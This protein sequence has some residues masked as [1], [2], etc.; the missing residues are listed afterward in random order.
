M[1]YTVLAQFFDVNK[2]KTLARWKCLW[3]TGDVGVVNELDSTQ[4]EES[5]M[6]DQE[7]DLPGMLA[8]AE[9]VKAGEWPYTMDARV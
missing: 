9:G 8:L 7:Q 4:I 6:A 3:Y 1:R 5:D 2:K